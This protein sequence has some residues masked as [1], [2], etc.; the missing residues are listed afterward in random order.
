MKHVTNSAIHSYRELWQTIFKDH[1]RDEYIH[2]KSGLSG[3]GGNKE[4]YDIHVSLPKKEITLYP[5]EK[6]LLHSVEK[7]HMPNTHGAF[8]FNK[9]TLARLFLDA[10]RTTYIDAG[11]IGFLT[12]EVKNESDLPI[13]IFN[14]QPIAQIVPYKLEFP[15]PGYVGKYQNQPD[16][17]VGAKCVYWKKIYFKMVKKLAKLKWNYIFPSA[18]R[19]S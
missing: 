2:E 4:T 7:F 8:V 3:G 14:G 10:S 12:I 11:F 5:D 6:I 13:R 19:R 16:Y 18:K 1:F 17:P 9:S 15:V